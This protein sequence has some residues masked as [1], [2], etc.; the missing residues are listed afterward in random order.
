MTS[1]QAA[2]VADAERLVCELREVGARLLA[3]LPEGDDGQ[4]RAELLSVFSRIRSAEIVLRN[5]NGSP[6]EPA[7]DRFLRSVCI[8]EPGAITTV[9]AA[10]AAYMTWAN[11]NGEVCANAD[12][13]DVRVEGS[14][15]L[16]KPLPKPPGCM[17]GEGDSLTVNAAPGHILFTCPYPAFHQPPLS[18]PASQTATPNACEHSPPAG[19]W[20]S[21]T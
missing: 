1:E 5:A 20:R 3:D 12:G 14:R 15:D 9:K 11:A 17:S 2:A 18:P 8:L 7:V 10:H 4:V 13:V 16:D 21:A 6:V 19:A